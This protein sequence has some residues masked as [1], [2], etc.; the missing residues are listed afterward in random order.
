MSWRRKREIAGFKETLISIKYFVFQYVASTENSCGNT[1]HKS[2]GN[3]RLDF[4]FL[5]KFS[6]Q[7]TIFRDNKQ[8]MKK[9]HRAS[10][11]CITYVASKLPTKLFIVKMKKVEVELDRN[12][13]I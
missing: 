1:T 4:C 6:I 10:S 12:D 3:N 5:K 11:F 7:T 9:K 2:G 8:L 13:R